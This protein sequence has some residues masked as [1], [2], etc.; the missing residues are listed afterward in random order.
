MLAGLPSLKELKCVNNNHQLTGNI[1]S[2]RALR[3]TLEDV[4]ICNCRDIEGDPMELA[5]FPSL[6]MLD[7]RNTAVVGDIRGIRK[8]DFSSLDRLILPKRVCGVEDKFQYVLS[9]GMLKMFTLTSG[10]SY[11][12][13]RII[14]VNPHELNTLLVTNLNEVLRESDIY[15]LFGE[16]APIVRVFRPNA[17]IC[18]IESHCSYAY[19]TLLSH[20]A[21]DAIE[22]LDGTVLLGRRL[23]VQKVRNDRKVSI[24]VAYKGRNVCRAFR[25]GHCLEHCP[26]G[27]EHRGMRWTECYSKYNT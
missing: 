17:K 1:K 16:F 26:F 4:R 8:T 10:R 22:V 20:E 7:L 25:K 11:N 23:Q 14:V 2:L 24:A 18:G 19:V 6:R 27:L 21:D 3:D 12:T 9:D 15:Y 13:W 5:D